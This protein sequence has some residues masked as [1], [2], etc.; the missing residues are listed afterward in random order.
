[1]ITS[2]DQRSPSGAG[3]PIWKEHVRN[4]ILN[5]LDIATGTKNP[6]QTSPSTKLGVRN[7]SDISLFT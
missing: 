2:P 6:P 3:H 1:M 4:L 7:N 5:L